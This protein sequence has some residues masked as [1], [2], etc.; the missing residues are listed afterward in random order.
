MRLRAGARVAAGAVLAGALLVGVPAALAAGV[1]WPLP[2][3]WPRPD[4]VVDRLRS[5]GVPDAFLVKALA[6]IVWL[7]WAHLAVCLVVE[8]AAAVRGR[9]ASRVPLGGAFQPLARWLVACLV[10]AS[11]VG[12]VRTA[13]A[14]PLSAVLAHVEPMAPTPPPAELVPRDSA[15]S[16]HDRYTVVPGDNLWDIAEVCVDQAPRGS[17]GDATASRNTRVARL[18]GEI[19][20]LNRGREQPDGRWLRKPDLIRPGWV[21]ELPDGARVHV[22][23]KEAPVAAE[24]SAAPPAPPPVP[25]VQPSSPSVQSS[26]VGNVRAVSS[27]QA[28]P[29]TAP[30]PAGTPTSHRSNGNR[31]AAAAVLGISGTA[32]AVGLARAIRRRR[33]DVISRA[34]AGDVVPAPSPEY[35]D[36]RRSI[37]VEGD[38][39]VVQHLGGAL[40][41]AASHLVAI[42]SS[43]RPRV[44]QVSR[45]GIEMLLTS[46]ATPAPDG[47]RAAASGSVWSTSRP[48]TGEPRECPAPTVVTLGKTTDGATLY[49]DLETE[50]AVSVVG[51]PESISGLARVM[52]IEL[53]LSP[54]GDALALLVVGPDP[55]LP[56]NLER[57]TATTDWA[58]AIDTVTAWAQQSSESLRANRHPSALHARSAGPASDAVTP[59]VVIAT[60]APAAEYRKRLDELPVVSAVA[61]IAVGW[62]AARSTRIEVAADAL[63]VPALGVECSPQLVD[64]E[65]ATAIEEVLEESARPATAA[66][67]EN[68]ADDD[69]PASATSD[70]PYTDPECDV[71][72][73]V[74][75]DIRIA[76]GRRPLTPLQ[77]A[78]VT[79]IALHSPT[80]A[81]R[82][83]D[84]VW[85]TPTA[86]RRK[87][88]ANTVSEAR[89]ALGAE[90]FPVAADGRYSVGPRVITDLAIAEARL[91]HARAQPADDAIEMLRGALELVSAPPFSYRAADRTSFVW[92]DL[93]N[94]AVNAE[95]LVIEAAVLLAELCLA[96]GDTEGAAWAA[97]R[98]LVASPAHS[99][100]TEL[101]MRA[102]ASGGDRRAA[103][104]VYANHVNA[105]HALDLDEV[106][107]STLDL[108][109][110]L[111]RHEAVS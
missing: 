74:L 87:R 97:T 82:V 41:Q 64:A 110:E 20:E 80:A 62:E 101:L 44:V 45:H 78:V 6:V 103:E 42:G 91:A 86:N 31:T 66:A 56:E 102:H 3:E 54:L 58:D 15:P 70:G 51:D 106:A 35:D 50:G 13:T 8:V 16:E 28:E 52:A 53:A 39:N 24:P 1:G 72:V 17:A 29:A 2:S 61:L 75:G 99:Q 98:G 37:A 4:D 65:T 107:E 83:E 92:V 27:E 33:R 46:A 5:G 21:L 59:L 89:S 95:L 48:A 10:A 90:H 69:A 105:L 96:R 25:A 63:R 47:W 68:E 7:A 23:A 94:W 111:C 67:A 100:L 32:L 22:I 14:A 34:R 84:A 85:T 60:A 40:A 55:D 79:Y 76:G 26:Q 43:A 57:V 30:A 19:F 38:E 36:L 12:P 108:H 9:V 73:C 104:R 18:V 77:T 93:E 109:D 49:L 81:E 11:A 71:M 88:L